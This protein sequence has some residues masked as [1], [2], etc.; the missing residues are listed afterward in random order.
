MFG[1][2]ARGEAIDGSDID[3]LVLVKSQGLW[4]PLH[5]LADEVE[6]ELGYP[7][8]ISLIIYHIDQWNKLIG[9]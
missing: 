6:Y 5:D 9:K 2:K 3:L 8:Y 4:K 7:G 1:S